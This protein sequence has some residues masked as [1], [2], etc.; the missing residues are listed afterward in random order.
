KNEPTSAAVHSRRWT[1]T[2][3]RRRYAIIASRTAHLANDANDVRLIVGAQAARARQTQA[4]REEVRRDLAA[5]TLGAPVE[6]LQVHRL[7]P[8]PRLDGVLRE[9]GEEL[10]ARSTEAL[11]VDQEHRQPPCAS[12][13]R[14]L[15]HRLEPIE[16]GERLAIALEHT[17]TRLDAR[18]EDGELPAAD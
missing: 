4:P 5:V 9:R 7:P 3:R 13:E 14:R 17:A 1:T 11:R 18:I 2:T 12:A 6:R 8:R 16:I 15:G 10:I